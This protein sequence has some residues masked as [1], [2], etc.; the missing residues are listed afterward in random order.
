MSRT[1]ARFS[2][3]LP[4]FAMAVFAL[5]IGLRADEAATKLG[6]IDVDAEYRVQSVYIDP[7]ELSG[8]EAQTMNYTEQRFRLE[9]SF[10]LGS[11]GKIKSQFDL[12]GGVLFGDNGDYGQEP[13]PSFGLA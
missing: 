8:T 6:S 3:S 5:P 11:I 2:L 10:S 1:L 9:P 12:L 4:L 7:L 13:E